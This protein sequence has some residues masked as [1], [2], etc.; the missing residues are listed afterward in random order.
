VVRQRVAELLLMHAGRRGRNPSPV[1][2]DDL[3]HDIFL[4]VLK[5]A[6]ACE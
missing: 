6:I 5:L 2:V 3:A 4:A 1:D